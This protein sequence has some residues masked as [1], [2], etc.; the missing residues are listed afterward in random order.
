MS[1]AFAAA[2]ALLAVPGLPIWAVFVILLTQGLIA[3]L[4]GEFAGDC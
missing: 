1:L 3:S 4:G 2:T